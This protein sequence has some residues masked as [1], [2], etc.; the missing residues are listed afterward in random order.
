MMPRHALR[1]ARRARHRLAVIYPHRRPRHPAH[2]RRRDKAG[3]DP[4]LQHRHRR[5]LR[6]AGVED[7]LTP[8][9]VIPMWTPEEAI[10]EL[11]FCTKQ[12]GAKVGHVRRRLSPAASR[13]ARSSMPRSAALAVRYENL[14]L[15][16][17]YDYDA[18]WQR[19]GEIGVSP[20]FHT[21]GRGFG[22]RDS[23]S[24]FVVNHIGHFAAASH[25]V[26]KAMFF[27]GVTRRFPD[28]RI[29]FLE[30]GV[31][32]A[33]QL[34][35][36]LVGHWERRGAR[37][38][39]TWTRRNLDRPCSEPGRQVRLRRIAAELDRARRLAPSEDDE[40]DRRRPARRVGRL[41]D[42]AARKTGSSSTPGR[43]TSAARP[44][45]P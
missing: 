20:T 44:T 3:R 34:F 25:A 11:E 39:R 41:R 45:T 26:A 6:Q 35:A 36:D 38:S 16:S 27:G 40:P 32:W 19:C 10:E 7:R 22:L 37:A 43:T 24:N 18:V 30:G 4:R 29:A 15:D 2:R 13:R 9:A 14:G 5:I 23:P 8:A 1:P 12:L 31:G 17:P 28:L 21:G 33:C 42:H